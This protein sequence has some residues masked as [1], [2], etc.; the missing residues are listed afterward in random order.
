[1]PR[2]DRIKRPWVADLTYVLTGAGWTY[3]AFVVDP[4]ARRIPAWRPSPR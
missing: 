4:Y 1:M 2:S 3:L